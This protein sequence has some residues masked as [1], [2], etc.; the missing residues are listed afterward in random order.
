MARVPRF[1]TEE[2]FQ[3]WVNRTPAPKQPVTR[4][5]PTEEQEQM[6]L[7]ARAR[8]YEGTYP[9]LA[10][11]FHVPNGGSRH[12]VE[13]KKLKSL[14]VLAGVPD[15]LLL[16]PAR[17]Y[18]GWAAEMKARDGKPTVEQKRM[19]R[20]LRERNYFAEFFYGQDA[21]WASLMW[22]LGENQ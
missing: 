19:I 8:L 14:G 12:V 4:L 17:G 9:A 11:L 6:A 5:T 15:L 3:A 16:H 1:Y 20:L 2:A 22:Y 10:L 7:I 18:H 21:A 13:A